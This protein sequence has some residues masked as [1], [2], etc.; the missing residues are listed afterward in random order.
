M[1]NGGLRG[2]TECPT[3]RVHRSTLKRIGIPKDE[4]HVILRHFAKHQVDI[5]R[6]MTIFRPL[7]NFL[8]GITGYRMEVHREL[9]WF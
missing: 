9:F 6:S 3:I 8:H 5:I 1:H 2:I 4:L 7:Y